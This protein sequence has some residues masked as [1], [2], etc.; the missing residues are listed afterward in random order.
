MGLAP[1]RRPADG[2]DRGRPAHPLAGRRRG[3]RARRV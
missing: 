2:H 3:Q 1:N